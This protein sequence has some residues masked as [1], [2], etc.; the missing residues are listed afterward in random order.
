MLCV[1]GACLI[2]RGGGGIFLSS[3][4]AGG[5]DHMGAHLILTACRNSIK[6]WQSSYERFNQYVVPRSSD[7]IAE[8]PEFYLVTVTVMK[9]IVDE[10]KQK[11]RESK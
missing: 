4:G 3:G 8:D 6:E 5:G 1:G 9:K 7:T 10:F 11:A 2:L